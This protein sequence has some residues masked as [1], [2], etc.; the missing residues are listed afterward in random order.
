MSSGPT[1]VWL[2]PVGIFD[3]SDGRFYVGFGDRY[4]IRSYGDD[5]TLQTIIRR[6]WKPTP[7]MAVALKAADA[8]P[9]H[10]ARDAVVGESAAVMPLPYSGN[11]TYREPAT[12][13][14]GS[15]R[16]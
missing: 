2:S 13:S 10:R 4:E 1:P 15:T 3:A 6:S 5:G 9:L 7:K 12:F 16:P 11:D 8:T 14:R